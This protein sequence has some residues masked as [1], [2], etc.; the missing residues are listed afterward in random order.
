MLVWT[1]V[2]QNTNLHD[3]MISLIGHIFGKQPGKQKRS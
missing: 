2:K 1:F 3:A